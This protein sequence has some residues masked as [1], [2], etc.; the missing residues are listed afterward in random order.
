MGKIKYQGD[1]DEICSI[2]T[3]VFERGMTRIEARGDY[4]VKEKTVVY[5][6]VNR[7]QVTKMKE[8]VHEIDDDAYIIISE[9]ADIFTLNN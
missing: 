8:T 2:L 1:T 9:I 4:S 5:F 7:F 6:T 3:K